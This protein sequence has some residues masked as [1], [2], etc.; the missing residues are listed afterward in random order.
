MEG[1]EAT[2]EK[3]GTWEIKDNK[4]IFTFDKSWLDKNPAEI[5]VGANFSF[6]LANKNAGS[7][8]STPIKFPGAGSINI[9]TTAGAVKGKKSGAFSQ[10]ADGVAKVTWSVKLTVESYAT[11][12]KFTDVLG[13]N[14][15]FVS[16]SFTLDSKKLDP[17]PTID[18]QT[19]T[20]DN[21][22]NLSGGG[23]TRSRMRR[24]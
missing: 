8:S 10:G 2:A 18:G 21:L 7:D 19:A 4:V 3:A 12:V 15:S 5:F 14:F 23:S 11:N 13:D 6:E 24:C 9:P 16:G 17:Q 1:P 22:G 20:I